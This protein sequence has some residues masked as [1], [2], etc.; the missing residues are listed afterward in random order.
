MNFSRFRGQNHYQVTAFHLR[1][2]FNY[3]FVLELFPYSFQ[4]FHALIGVGDLPPT[5]KY[6]YLRLVLLGEKTLDMADFHLKIVLVGLRTNLYL[7]YL[8]HGLLL[9]RLLGP[10]VLL[11][12]EFSVIHYL[13][14]RGI[15]IRGHFNEI[16]MLQRGQFQRLSDWNDPK[17]LAVMPNHPDFRR[18]N[19]LIHIG[20]FLQCRFSF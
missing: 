15:G 7:L 20:L 18:S 13:A 12:F 4:N 17:L 3:D 1:V 8:D 5:E 6:R 11:V 14:N 16:Q 19:F 2:L 10:L 9:F